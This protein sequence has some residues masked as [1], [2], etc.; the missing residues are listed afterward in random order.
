MMLYPHNYLDDD[1]DH[2]DNDIYNN[3]DDDEDDNDDDNDHNY[4]TNDDQERMADQAVPQILTFL[5]NMMIRK[6]GIV[7]MML[8]SNE[9]DDHYDYSE[10]HDHSSGD[11]GKQ[12]RC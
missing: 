4:G 12:G 9:Y 5:S 3:H 11:Y 6:K 8:I 1:T 10:H 7:I 2:D